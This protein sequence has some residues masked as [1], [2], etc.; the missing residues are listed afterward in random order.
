VIS[1]PRPSVFPR[2][3]A[4]SSNSLSSE[5]ELKMYW[6]GLGVRGRCRC[7]RRDV[8]AVSHKEAGR[9]FQYRNAKHGQVVTH[10][11]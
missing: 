5:E 4:N 3:S 8:D 1:V 9:M 10:L 11:L 7:N 2:G 6:A